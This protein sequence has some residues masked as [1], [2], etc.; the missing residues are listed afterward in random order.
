MGW[1]RKVSVFAKSR[2]V[3]VFAKSSVNWSS[4]SGGK[5]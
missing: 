4:L 3:S 5:V 2:K 1:S